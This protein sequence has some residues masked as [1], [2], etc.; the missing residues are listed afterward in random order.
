MSATVQTIIRRLL[1]LLGTFVGVL[2][3]PSIA[4]A[5]EAGGAGGEA[6]LIVPDLSRVTF[7]G[8]DGH[9]LLL[10]GLVISALGLL[11]G[12]LTFTQLKALPVHR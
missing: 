2:A 11:F 9:T 6:S 10:S 4:A 12:L 1:L 3:L 7:L 8:V 5:Q